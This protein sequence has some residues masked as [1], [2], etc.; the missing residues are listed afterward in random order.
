MVVV[1]HL[2][3]SSR[4]KLCSDSVFSDRV[5]CSGTE[6]RLPVHMHYPI[7]MHILQNNAY[8]P[9]CII[10]ESTHY[11]TVLFIKN[12]VIM[13][14]RKYAL[15]TIYINPLLRICIN[16]SQTVQGHCPDRICILVHCTQPIR[17]IFMNTHYNG[18]F[19]ST[20][21]TDSKH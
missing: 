17:I 21:K 20:L 15:V 13:H 1:M 2:S 4:A 19:T 6:F 7:I 8:S 3:P 11:Y 10:V 5:Q 9:I 16:A 18:F 12:S 14:I